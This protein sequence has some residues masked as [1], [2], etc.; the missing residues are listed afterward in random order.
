[1]LLAQ[2]VWLIRW[3]NYKPPFKTTLI[4]ENSSCHF[5]LGS[6]FNDCIRNS[7]NLTDEELYAIVKTGVNFIVNSDAHA[8]NRVG[9]ISLAKQVIERVGIS[10]DRIVNIDGKTPKFRFASFKGGV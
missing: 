6:G 10:K 3:L 2:A 9:E 8:P 7:K 5:A 4:D 1:M